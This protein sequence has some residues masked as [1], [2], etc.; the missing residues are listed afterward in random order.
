[1]SIKKKQAVDGKIA[2]L[3]KI[4]DSMDDSEVIEI[5]FDGEISIMGDCDEK[6]ACIIDPKP[7]Y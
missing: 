4:L 3:D 7:A 5:D 6:K 2:E 1:M